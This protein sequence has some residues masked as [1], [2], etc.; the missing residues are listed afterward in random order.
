MSDYSIN[1]TIG[2]DDSDFTKVVENVIT[3]LGDIS[4]SFESMSDSTKASFA[5]IAN[6]FQ[7]IDG[8]AKVWGD[9][10]DVIA[11]KQKTLKDAIN[12]LIDDGIAPESQQIQ[13]LKSAYD[14]LGESQDD[15]GKKSESLKDKFADLRDI[16]QGPIEAAKLIV[17]AFKE[18]IKTIGELSEEFAEDETAQVKFESAIELS[19]K[20]TEGAAER[21]NTLAEA[22]ASSTGEANSAAQSQ[23]AM[24]VAT[25]RSES[26][27][28]KMITAAKG[29]SVATGVDLDTALTQINATF[30]GTIGRLGKTTPALNDLSKE[31]IENGGAVDVLIKKY[32]EMGDALDKTSDVS[33]KNNANQWGEVKSAIGK[34]LEESVKPMRDEMTEMFKDFVK[35]AG[36]SDNLKNTLKL[37]GD[38]L[39][40]VTIGVIAFTVATNWSAIMAVA[41]KAI[42]GLSLAL[43]GM[44]VALGTATGGISLAIAA[45]VT[46]ALLVVQNWDEVQKFLKVALANIKLFFVT[47]FQSIK[48]AL[49]EFS[50]VISDTLYGSIANLLN[51]AAKIPV[52]GGAFKGA[53]DGVNEFKKSID[54]SIDSAKEE[55]KQAIKTATTERDQAVSLSKIKKEEISE[56]EKAS[57]KAN[58]N[59]L[60]GNKKTDNGIILSAAAVFDFKTDGLFKNVFDNKLAITSLVTDDAFYVEAELENEKKLREE[61][62][63]TAKMWE[64][65]AKQ[66]LTAVGGE[67]VDVLNSV[68][69]TTVDIVKAV[70]SN[71]T[72]IQADIAAVVD[73][74]GLA[75]KED[76][77]RMAELQ[78]QLSELATELLDALAPVLELVLEVLIDTMPILLELMPILKDLFDILEPFLPLVR[79]FVVVYLAPLLI[80]LKL[81]N[82]TLQE[83]KKFLEPVRKEFQ[84]FGEWADDAGSNLVNGFTDGIND[85]GEQIW[86]NVKGVF[87]GFWDDACDFFGIHSPSTMFY[88][89]GGNIIQGL[90][91][92][93]LN[94]GSSLWGAVSGIFTG[95]ADNIQNV[96][97]GA[98]D[99]G[100]SIASGISGAVS[101]AGSAVSNV[102]DNIVSGVSDFIDDLPFLANG[103]DF[104]Q[105]GYA[106]VGEQGPE[107][108][109]LPRG[110]SVTPAG[111]TSE[112]LSGGNKK[113]DVNQTFNIYAGQSLSAAD[114]ARETKRAN[115]RL[116]SGV[117]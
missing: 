101:G 14:K 63:A 35:W 91:D 54:G 12:K 1:A 104:H 5:D 65:S 46:G 16:M 83:M 42:Q 106:V 20:M 117:A 72:D 110:T 19:S 59:V 13:D 4:K 70:A 80:G 27:I 87:S 67:G 92:G 39:A 111:K 105:G 47:A 22:L 2:A 89:M 98:M 38:I 40:G 97:S 75:G 61:R 49:F 99:V 84:K 108:I 36:T 86:E 53:A 113:G 32:G 33:I 115:R 88:D 57:E 58:A 45:I 60:A 17:D 100:S 116:A 74:I 3:G 51:M 6:Q 56:L 11:E 28:N 18:V 29:L 9:S 114:I 102:V 37:M 31:E 71:F 69:T 112:I 21:L 41:V 8:K 25:G 55:A 82:W 76:Q 66:V 7:A 44:G 78:G 79:A 77:G 34:V 10:T 15:T 81:I 50:K 62:N 107:L 73:I 109:S 48:I 30:S 68:I 90:I 95:L 23:I 93:L 96:V 52:I 43:S 103:T 64:D 24:L 26:E 94:A 85:A